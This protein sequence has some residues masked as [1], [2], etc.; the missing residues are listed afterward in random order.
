MMGV[1]RD[2][3]SLLHVFTTPTGQELKGR[4]TL[5][6][7]ICAKTKSQKLGL[8]QVSLVS[9]SEKHQGLLFHLNHVPV[10][11]NL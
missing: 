1:C 5:G 6:K 3:L 8:Q 10:L 9:F 7:S 4:S 2:L 11:H